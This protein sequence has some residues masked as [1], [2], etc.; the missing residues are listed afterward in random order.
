MDKKE[1]IKLIIDYWHRIA[2]HHALWYGEAIHQFGREKAF[3]ILK[4]AYSRGLD[5]HMKRL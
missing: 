4:S 1:T 2:M 3:D 5:I